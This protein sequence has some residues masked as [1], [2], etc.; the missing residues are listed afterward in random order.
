MM[1]TDDW[2]QKMNKENISGVSCDTKTLNPRGREGGREGEEV[3]RG[4]L[5]LKISVQAKMLKHVVFWTILL[6]REIFC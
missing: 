3:V 2:F 6:L 4:A 5:P 1:D